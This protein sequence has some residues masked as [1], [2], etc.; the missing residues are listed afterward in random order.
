MS[1]W[2]AEDKSVIAAI[3]SPED[4]ETALECDVTTIFLLNSDIFNIKSLV[5]RIRPAVK[6]HL[7]M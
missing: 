5:D 4:L 6:V 2:K 1:Y 3:R 7:F